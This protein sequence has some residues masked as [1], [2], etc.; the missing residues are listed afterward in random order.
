MALAYTSALVS[1]FA[2][3]VRTLARSLGAPNDFC[4]PMAKPQRMAIVT[5]LAVY[6]TIVPKSWQMEWSETK[7][8]LYIVI[9]GGAA[10]CIRRLTRAARQLEKKEL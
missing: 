2:A 10:T 3:Y 6:L 9:L 1:V 4:G 7:L 8:V 5:L